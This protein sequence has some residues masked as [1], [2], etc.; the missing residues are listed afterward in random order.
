M[1]DLGC[2]RAR[3]AKVYIG[4]EQGP[5]NHVDVSRDFD[6]PYIISK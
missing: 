4:Q 5:V 6:I 3:R 1:S 2:N